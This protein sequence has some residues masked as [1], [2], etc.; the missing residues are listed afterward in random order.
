M[1]EVKVVVLPALLRPLMRRSQFFMG[2]TIT[3]RAYAT[4]NGLM[5]GK[6]TKDVI[7][8]SFPCEK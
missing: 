6:A 8:E 2:S 5:S 7:A 4:L 3:E 1:V